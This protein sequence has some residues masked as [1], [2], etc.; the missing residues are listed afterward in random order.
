MKS[1]T[2][3]SYT[4]EGALVIQTFTGSLKLEPLF[5]KLFHKNGTVVT[6][7]WHLVIRMAEKKPLPH[8]DAE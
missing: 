3:Q 4:K 5:V 1:V 6:I 7:P 2:Y 8:S